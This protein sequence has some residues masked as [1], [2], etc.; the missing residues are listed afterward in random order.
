VIRIMYV[1]IYI[2][3]FLLSRVMYMIDMMFII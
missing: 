3:L 2:R 1:L